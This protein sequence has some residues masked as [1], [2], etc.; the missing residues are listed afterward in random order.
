MIISHKDHDKS[1]IWGYLEALLSQRTH[2]SFVV[3]L[4]LSLAIFFQKNMTKLNQ[5]K[6]RCALYVVCQVALP[7]YANGAT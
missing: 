1:H 4:N 6:P 3:G 2:K 7:S 5:E